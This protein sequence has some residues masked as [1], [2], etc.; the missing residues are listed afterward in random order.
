MMA[1]SIVQALYKC[2]FF[3]YRRQIFLT[4]FQIVCQYP[5]LQGVELSLPTPFLGWAG[6]S[7]LLLRDSLQKD[8]DRNSAMGKPGNHHLNLVKKVQIISNVLWISGT[9]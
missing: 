7:I 3:K 1:V 6:F 8:K 2:V 9:P 5:S 4:E